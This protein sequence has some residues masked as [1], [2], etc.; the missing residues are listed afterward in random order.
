MSDLTKRR[1]LAA[2]PWLVVCVPAAYQIVLLA[3]A[4]AGRVNYPYD[5]EWMEGG[6]LHHAMRIRD[7]QG[8]Y[9]PPSIDFI[10]YL[11]T[12]LYPALLAMMSGFTGIS[13]TVGRAVSVLSL[14]G[15]TLNAFFHI[16]SRRHQHAQLAPGLAGAL[17]GIALFASAYP[18]TEGW[19]DL[20][21]ADTLFLWIVTASL[22][23][24]TRWATAGEGWNGHARI[25]AAAAMLA[26]AFF[27]KQTGIFYVALGGLIVLV[28]APR[29][30]IT[31]IVVSG[32]IGLGGVALL[33][34]RTDG[35]FWI[36]IRKIHQAHDFN[37]D[38][39]VKSFSN[40]LWHVPAMAVVI[41]VTLLA[42]LVTR[43]ARRRALPRGTHP[44]MLWAATYAVSTIV[45]AIGWGTE[46]AHYNAY[47][48]AFLHG[49][50]AAGAA[51]P[52]LAAITREWC[53][54]R[55]GD[56]ATER[57]Y[58]GLL[59]H[60]VAFAGAAALS[61]ACWN[62]RWNPQKFIPTEADVDAGNRLITRL[63]ELPGD[64]WMPSHPWYL[65]LAG[66]SPHVHRM[67]IKDVTWRQNRTVAK[68]DEALTNHA[69]TAI[70]LDDRDLNLEVPKLAQ[71]YRAAYNLT[72]EEQPRVYTGAQVHPA[73][74]WVPALPVKPPPD[75][76]LVF[77]FE[78]QNW[79]H[80]KVTGGAWGSHPATEAHPSQGIVVGA[81]GRSFA[82]SAMAGDSSEGRL[83][84]PDFLL[85]GK[86]TVHMG[87]TTDPQLRVELWVEDKI[88][89]SA[90]VPSLTG[91]ELRPVTLDPGTNVNA[92]GHLVFVDDSPTGHMEVDDVWVWPAK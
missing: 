84:S 38:R 46:F 44:F 76:H 57:R 36:Y 33:Q 7:G 21:R 39:F 91:D 5:L 79:E 10:P 19:Y 3:T 35:W 90:R 68:L 8:I 1:L 72:P 74:V 32:V 86:V 81:T 48:P 92:M 65:A 17:I 87:G 12:P 71:T 14:V 58:T 75:A 56:V 82:N 41:G 47:M 60:L 20:V 88:I 29:R 54:K 62:A 55:D 42:L 2:V 27:A 69:F 13:Y 49:G 26:L 59:S 63:R 78:N 73:T 80:W 77:D 70:V 37:H 40:I 22:A 31:Y 30:V 83:T 25:A 89:A 67:G 34:A 18:Y 51:L 15:I 23:G 50:L 64:V 24:I 6:M 61:V 11:Y 66:K 28:T 52:A 53:T 9:V 4:I 43:I 45:G 85:E 16:N